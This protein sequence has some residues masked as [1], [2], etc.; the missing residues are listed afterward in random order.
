[1]AAT[2]E[3]KYFNSFWL[4]RLKTMEP[5]RSTTT[6][7]IVAVAVTNPNQVQFV[8]QLGNDQINVGDNVLKNNGIITKISSIPGGAGQTDP[9]T[10][11]D[12][13][14]LGSTLLAVGDVLTF[15]VRADANGT[16]VTAI[17]INA[18]KQVG[19]GQTVSGFPTA[20]GSPSSG[21][22]ISYTYNAAG[23]TDFV[24]DTPVNVGAGISLDFTDLND[25]S[26]I[27][28]LYNGDAV[29]DWYV[30][31]SRI[32][33]GYNNTSVDLG[34]KAYI[35]EDNPQQQHRFNSMIYSGVF[36]S[37]TGVNNTNQ[38]SVG[39][40]IT[41]SLNPIYAS[42]QKLYAEDTNL[43]IFQEEKVSRALIDKD[44]IFSAEGAPI[45]TSGAQVI[46]QV[47]GYA[48]EY[49]ISKDPQSFA[50]YGYRKY[51]TDRKRNCVCRLSKDG[52]TEISSYGMHDFFRDELSNSSVNNVVGAWDMHTKN[53]VLSIQQQKNGQIGQNGG[54]AAAVGN[55]VTVTLNAQIGPIVAGD[56]IYSYT[57]S[58]QITGEFYGTIVSVTTVGSPG[59]PAVFVAN[60]T[61][62]IPALQSI[63]CW[64]EPFST[65]M[66]DE[67][68]LGWTSFISFKPS[69]MISS[70]ASFYST[71]STGS[72]VYK[73]HTLNT[74]YLNQYAN[75]YGV[76]NHS[77]VTLVLNAN[78][79]VVKNFKTINYE[80]GTEWEMNSFTAS[81]VS[82]AIT[83]TLSST[84]VKTTGLPVFKYYQPLTLSDLEASLW[85]NT[86]KRK[87]NKYFANIVNSTEVQNAEVIFGQNISGV[88]G[89][90]AETKFVL[91][92]NKGYTGG[93]GKKELFSISSE[94]VESSY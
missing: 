51:F 77:S 66:F 72:I 87:E 58:G 91:D 84:N 32:R 67:T 86:F 41:R 78:P 54:T 85:A 80:G 11:F 49:G 2:L 79:S 12:C 10:I 7:G 17:Q 22:I 60:L 13:D 82:S 45:T 50:V 6:T 89:F 63:I 18:S 30:E 19:P 27:P 92:N 1:M 39:T 65:A 20:G 55:N 34:V 52:I 73:H 46:G 75:F 94:I 29:N 69:T 90:F 81:E 71:S 38:F 28:K 5:V 62:Q 56:N 33:A 14:S 4:K 15:K 21:K 3:L 25:F 93:Y 48:G 16:G 43:I 88:K 53:Y 47:V 74:D 70:G 24:I 59:N 37:R 8:L 40:D 44:A 9:P 61:T 36:N 23:T 57:A 31:E 26:Y 76:T 42:I 64:R 83:P 68:V 35:V